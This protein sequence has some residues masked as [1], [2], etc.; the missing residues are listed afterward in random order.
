MAQALATL[1][2]QLKSQKQ[3]V[4]ALLKKQ[5]EISDRGI[6]KLLLSESP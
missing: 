2:V 6:E 4:D 3:Q 1:S 5:W